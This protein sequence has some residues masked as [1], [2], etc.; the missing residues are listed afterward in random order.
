MTVVNVSG[1]ISSETVLRSSMCILY[2]SMIQGCH[3]L[4]YLDMLMHELSH[5]Y[6]DCDL[7]FGHLACYSI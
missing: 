2:T 7:Q 6:S 5:K 4:Q 1:Q 3:T